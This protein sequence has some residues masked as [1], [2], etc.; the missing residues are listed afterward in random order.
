MGI[1]LNP[2]RDCSFDTNLDI[3]HCRLEQ[4]LTG[5]LIAG[6]SSSEKSLLYEDPNPLTLI[7]IFWYLIFQ[8]WL[9]T[10]L[11]ECPF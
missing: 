11:T 6:F 3:F 9:S 10:N 1:C 8:D 7:E 2:T 4:R 5:R